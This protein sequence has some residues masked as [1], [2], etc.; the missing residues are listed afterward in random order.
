MKARRATCRSTALAVALAVMGLLSGCP[1]KAAT[2]RNATGPRPQD[3]AEWWVEHYGPLPSDDP[4]AVRARSIFERVQAASERRENRPGKLVLLA[5]GPEPAAMALRDGAIILTQGGLDYCLEGQTGEAGD[6]RLAFVLGH[7]LAH[8]AQDDFAHALTFEALVG[9][10][11]E[12]SR[13]FGW[14]RPKPEDHSR[15]ELDADQLG[16]LAMT[17]A[18]FEPQQI[19]D[20]S[21]IKGWVELA[22][23]SNESGTADPHTTPAQRAIA[24]HQGLESIVA[25]LPLFAFGTRLVAIGRLDDGILLLQT[26]NESFPSREV[27]SNLGVGYARQALLTLGHCDGALISRLRMPMLLDPH[28]LAD[29]TIRRGSSSPC[30]EDED[31]RRQMRQALVALEAAASRDPLHRPS[32]LNLA[33]A[34]LLFDQPARAYSQAKD[35]LGRFP[36]DLDVQAAH[37]VALYNFGPGSGLE[38]ADQ[39]LKLLDAVLAKDPGHT[40]ALYNSAAILNERGRAAA[41]QDAWRRFLQ[42]ESTGPWAETARA[43][44]GLP[45]PARR[46]GSP[47]PEALVTDVAFGKAPLPASVLTAGKKSD[48]SIGELLVETVQGKRTRVLRLGGSTELIETVVPALSADAKRSL[49]DPIEI[50]PLAQGT[51]TIYPDF[52]LEEGDETVFIRFA[53][54]P[55]TGR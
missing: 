5:G 27:L 48:F 51:L 13:L 45:E 34:Q 16:I 21:F 22:S 19:L 35:T 31:T 46:P 40:V 55:P 8:L 23:Q 24:L 33:A 17:F 12:R 20:G 4:R 49:G 54:P 10:S 50:Q 44:L 3:R 39:A 1:D 7:E 11:P 53:P 18:G 32:Q 15:S 25:E 38:T 29:R 36:D 47:L 6:A 28:T 30:Y 14:L 42:A 52:A 43:W 2:K 37:A 41:A 9:N 26:F